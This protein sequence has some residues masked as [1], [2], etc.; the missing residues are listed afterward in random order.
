[1]IDG[2]KVTVKSDELVKHLAARA[3]HHAMRV[4]ECEKRCK[5]IDDNPDKYG[6][7]N[8]SVMNNIASPARS[9]QNDLKRHQHLAAWFK[10]TAGHVEPSEEFLLE[11]NELARLE[12]VPPAAMRW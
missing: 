3:E 8:E 4:I 11:P 1:M 12:F 2:F 6:L 10:F 7:Q 9:A 5:D